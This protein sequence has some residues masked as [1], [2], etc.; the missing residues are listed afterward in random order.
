LLIGG[1]AADNLELTSV[2]WVNSKGGSG[3]AFSGSSTAVAWSDSV[4]LYSGDNII[5]VTATD[6][7]GYSTS[8]VIT[9]T[10]S[11]EQEAPGILITLPSG[12]GSAD[13]ATQVVT[14]AG[15]AD[16]NLGVV[17]VKWF[18]QTTG[19]RGTMVLTPQVPPTVPPSYD[20]SGDVPLT[21]GPNVIVV[22]AVDDANN[23]TSATITVT[24]T[25][26]PDTEAP[27][28]V[29]TGP[30]G[31]P[32]WDEVA[33]PMLLTVTAFDNIGIAAVSYTN[34][35]TGVSGT[36]TPGLANT[37]TALVGL[38]PGPNVLEV[39]A[40]DA[41]GNSTVDTIVVTFAPAP[42]DLV[43]PT[44]VVTKYSTGALL[45]QDYVSGTTVNVNVPNL[46]IAGTSADGVLVAGI[47]WSNAAG[48]TTSSG[49]ADGTTDWTAFLVLQPGLNV[50]TVKAYDSSGLWTKD[51]ITVQYTPPPFVPTPVHIQAGACGLTGLE[52]L[53]AVALA[54][55][56]RRRAR[57]GAGR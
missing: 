25:S 46:D 28:N 6:G 14:L 3:T 54:A 20:W 4:Y 34:S 22:T 24:Y 44:V 27:T 47:V 15:T 7:H 45:N 26:P 39:T 30:T 51:T 32:T 43:P 48:L 40:Y 37:W 5:T 29:I 52:V 17:A 13:S 11:L 56:L 10:F 35:G 36:L 53:L 18:N 38:V 19:I 49:T 55:S 1:N 21:N 12:S 50:V 42:G 57:K 33:A 16:D 9:V 41:V 31:N 8:A 23:R 2:T